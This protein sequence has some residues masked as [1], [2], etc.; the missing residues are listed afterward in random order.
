[1]RKHNVKA[2]SLRAQ[3]VGLKVRER[4]VWGTKFGAQ[5]MVRKVWGAKYEGAKHGGAK[6]VNPINVVKKGSK[7][8]SLF[9]YKDFIFA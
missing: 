3:S 2:R 6:L 5:S 4:Q 7:Y 1:M 8:P 9:F